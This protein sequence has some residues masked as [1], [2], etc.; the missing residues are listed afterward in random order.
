MHAEYLPVDLLEGVGTPQSVQRIGY[1]FN[2]LQG[3]GISSAESKP[4]LGT[5]QSP[6][7]WLPRALSPK[8]KPQEREADKSSPSHPEVKNDA[9][10][11]PLPHALSWHT[12]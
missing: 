11:S 7:K 10:I 9:A 12:A 2:S 4:A 5:T 1:G 8:V 6:I 3:Q